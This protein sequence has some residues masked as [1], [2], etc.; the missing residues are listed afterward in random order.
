M[1]RFKR[2]H[3]NVKPEPEEEKEQHMAEL[4]PDIAFIARE[5][6]LGPVPASST[7]KT[8]KK[9]KKQKKKQKKKQQEKTKRKWNDLDAQQEKND[10]QGFEELLQGSI[11]KDKVEKPAVEIKHK[12][13]CKSWI[14]EGFCQRGDE[15][16]L[17]HSLPPGSFPNKPPCYHYVN[18]GHCKKSNCE[19]SHEITLK[20]P[21]RISK[22]CYFFKSGSCGK[23]DWCEFMHDLKLETCRF[24]IR[25]ACIMGDRCP[26]AHE[27]LDDD[28]A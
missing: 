26:Y 5:L 12:L 6:G 10:A 9:S 7:E 15:C 25:N 22:L 20:A 21:H 24:W 3:A 17:S 8:V 19:Y 2:F 4:A 16:T 13:P 18:F 28:E 23:G 27:W 11:E 14:K 1:P